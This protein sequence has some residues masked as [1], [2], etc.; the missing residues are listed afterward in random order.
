MQQF[1]ISGKFGELKQPTAMTTKTSETQC[2]ISGMFLDPESY[3]WKLNWSVF[4]EMYFFTSQILIENLL[5][6]L[7]SF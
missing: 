2:N 5:N 3:S 7:K 6:S 1:Y 4:K